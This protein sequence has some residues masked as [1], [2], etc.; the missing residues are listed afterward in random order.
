MRRLLRLIATK[1][2][3]DMKNDVEFLSAWSESSH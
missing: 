2:A 1:S 3:D